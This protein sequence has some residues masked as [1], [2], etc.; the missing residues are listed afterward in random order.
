VEHILH[1]SLFKHLHSSADD[2][3]LQRLRYSGNRLILHVIPHEIVCLAVVTA[4]LLV[5]SNPDIVF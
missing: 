4:D 2:R 5:A 3:S 1:L